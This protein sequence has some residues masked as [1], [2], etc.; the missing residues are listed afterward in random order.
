MASNKRSQT[1]IIA[2]TV[3]MAVL[4][5]LNVTTGSV[6]IPL[7][8]IWN[9][10]S[11]DET[12]KETWRYIVL[13]SRIP[14]AITALLSGASLAVCGLMLQTSFNNPLAGPSIFGINSGA[15]LG[16]AVVLLFFGGSL[17]TDILTLSGFV[18]IIAGAIIGSL[19]V[20][21]L[22]LIFS[23][24]IKSN[25]ALLIVGIMVGYISSAAISILNFFAT[26][27]SIASY[28]M[29]GMGS[30]NNVTIEHIPA[31][32]SATTVCIILSLLLIKPLNALLLGDSYARNLGINTQHT[33]LLLL[34]LTG[35][36][37]AVTTAYCGPVAFIGLAVPH[38]ARLSLHTDNQ[39][40]L[41]PC[42]I[43]TGSIM[44]L[45][46]NLLSTMP[47]NGS[48]IPLNAITPI[49]GAPVIIYIVVKQRRSIR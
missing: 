29:W 47:S 40:E 11:G 27:Q 9:I 21:A 20:I 14:A 34:L 41:M 43:L 16:V 10:V 48:I 22:L 13:Q 4:F 45:L 33:R 2:A 5:V 46:C 28:V 32:T 12:E 38:I 1:Y 31:F 39:T 6:E 37:T 19:A 49:I 23:K 36:Q 25:V 30:F 15:S 35:V 8:D 7:A 42:T 17:S 18:A 3:A 44:A 24:L 26:D